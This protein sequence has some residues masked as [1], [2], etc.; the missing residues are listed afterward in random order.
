MSMFYQYA[1]VLTLLLLCMNT[2]KFLFSWM[3]KDYDECVQNPCVNGGTCYNN[4]G[5]YTCYCPAGWTGP[6]CEIG[7]ILSPWLQC[8]LLIVVHPTVCYFGFIYNFDIVY[9]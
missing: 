1:Y 7:K 9:R 5:S 8:L 3:F 4:E 2:H 6:N